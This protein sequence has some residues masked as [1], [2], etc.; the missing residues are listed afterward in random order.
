MAKITRRNPD[1][2]TPQWRHIIQTEH[3]EKFQREKKEQQKIKQEIRRK[4]KEDLN[5]RITDA[6][7]KDVWINPEFKDI[8]QTAKQKRMQKTLDD[9]KFKN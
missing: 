6:E 1:E 4:E 9:K 3:E 7:M 8:I 5:Y 2:S